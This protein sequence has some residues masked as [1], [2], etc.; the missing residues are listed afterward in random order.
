[1]SILDE[2][3]RPVEQQTVGVKRR[4]S[5]RQM[6][7]AFTTTLTYMV[8]DAL[9]LTGEETLWTS[10]QIK[11]ALGQFADQEPR[12]LPNAVTH[13]LLTN[14]YSKSVADR[15]DGSYLT[16]GESREPADLKGWIDVLMEMVDSSY[17]PDIMSSAQVR[18]KFTAILQ[19]LGVGSVKNP[20]A[21]LYLPN[22]IRW[23][24][25]Q[26]KKTYAY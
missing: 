10:Y 24:A 5:P 12:S 13:E 1:M 26:Q 6:H 20:R 8:S 7:S 22:A 14:Q 17:D 2:L 23:N 19:Q 4:F 25:A 3:S 16:S 18:A 15:N 9:N 11:D 21:T